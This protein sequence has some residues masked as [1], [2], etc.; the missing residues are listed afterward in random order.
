MCSEGAG[1]DLSAEG[2]SASRAGIGATRDNFHVSPCVDMFF[3]LE[4]LQGHQ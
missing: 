1:E 3:R 4:E 2:E